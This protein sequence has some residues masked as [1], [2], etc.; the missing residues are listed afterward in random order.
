M[1]RHHQAL[2]R[3]APP[4]CGGMGCIGRAVESRLQA[5][6]FGNFVSESEHN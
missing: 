6:A 2:C 3:G 4:L 1:L 5:I